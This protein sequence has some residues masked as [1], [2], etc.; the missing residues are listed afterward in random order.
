MRGQEYGFGFGSVNE[1]PDESTFSSPDN[2]KGDAKKRYGAGDIGI[3]A[4]GGLGIIFIV[5]ACRCAVV[6]YEI[7]K[8][9]WGD[10]CPKQ[11]DRL[12]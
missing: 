4:R 12:S 9:A 7:E 8:S 2:I 6:G 5:N 3:K 1:R 10:Q 11:G